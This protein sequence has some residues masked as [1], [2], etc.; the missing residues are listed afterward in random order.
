MKKFV[1]YLFGAACVLSTQSQASDLALSL[2]ACA[3]KADSLE[4]LVCYDNI[5][6][7]LDKKEAIS[8]KIS[9]AESA[10]KPVSVAV[11]AKAPIMASEAKAKPPQLN[12]PTQPETFNAED[13]FGA[14]REYVRQEQK[15][16]VTFV[17]KSVSKT[18]RGKYKFFFENG[19]LWEQKDTD[20]YGKF[21]AGETV[22][23]KRGVLD[24]FYLKKPNT[25][26]TIRVKR[27][28]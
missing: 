21:A 13:S 12:S 27:V 24:A 20:K 5:T 1:C 16:Q 9:S 28:K 15:N 14:E 8:N 11:A 10:A 4:R 2:K 25:N 26:R 6:Q 7:S 19:Q 3:T 17:I 18:L 23:I 22:I